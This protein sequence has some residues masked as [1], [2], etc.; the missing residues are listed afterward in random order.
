M[1]FRSCHLG[2]AFPPLTVNNKGEGEDKHFTGSVLLL[3]PTLWLFLHTERQTMNL[4]HGVLKNALKYKQLYCIPPIMFCYYNRV[5]RLSQVYALL[6][7]KGDPKSQQALQKLSPTFHF[8]PCHQNSTG[9]GKAGSGKGTY[10]YNLIL[11]SSL[12]DVWMLK[13]LYLYCII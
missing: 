5:H 9:A 12:L 11:F 4:L 13:L 8:L 3:P 2:F 6:R 10:S 7:Y 1:C